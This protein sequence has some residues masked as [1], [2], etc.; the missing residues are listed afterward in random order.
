MSAIDDPH[1]AENN[2]QP[3]ADQRQAGNRVKD[4]DRQKST[5][6][7]FSA[8]KGFDRRPASDLDHILLVVVRVFDEIAHRGGVGRLLLREVFQ[9]LELLVVDF[10]DM[11]VQDAMMGRWV[12]RNLARRSIDAD[13]GFQ[14]LDDLDSVDTGRLL[15]RLRPQAET[16]IG[17]HC[18]PGNV[19]VIGAEALVKSGNEDFVGLVLQVLEVILA[20]QY[21]VA[22]VG[23]QYDVLVTSGEGDR[24]HRNALEH[25]GRGPLAIERDMRAADER[26]PY[27]V[28]LRRLDLGDGRTEIRDVERE[29]VDRWD[30]TAVFGDVFLHPLRGDLAVIVIGCDDIDLFAPF[31]HGVRHELLNGLRRRY[32]G[33][34]L[35]AVADA[36]FILRIVEIQ[37]LETVEHRPD[38]FARG[39]GNAALHDGH[40]VLER[41]LL[42][43]LRVELHVRLRIVTDQL[44]LPAKQTAGRIGFLDGKRQCIDHRVSVDV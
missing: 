25:A 44:D 22:F 4:L 10:G 29:E 30:L 7:T 43:E 1:H 34:K 9:H 21:S 20:D 15:D 28:R 33:V 35:V 14:R 32:A 39:R 42:G 16:L 17:C 19:G 13:S 41:R 27:E 5:R 37:R 36:A 6:S 11:H 38:H 18:E 23:R 12:D 2:R 24:R 31:L 3:D 26:R 8:P 40:L